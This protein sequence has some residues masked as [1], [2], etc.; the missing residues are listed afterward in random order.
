[1]KEE[2]NKEL[3]E[4]IKKIVKESPTESPSFD[5]TETVMSRIT[6]LNESKVTVYRPLI[7]KLI[8]VFVVILFLSLLIYALL[9]GNETESLGWFD[10]LNY[11]F[12]ADS[13]SG[14]EIS[15]TTLYGITFF[16]VMLCLQ[17]PLLKQHF[18]KHLAAN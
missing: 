9:F 7:S 12:I 14:L 10:T 5:F 15:K 11:G 17:I 3:N 16:T 18:D 4:F 13:F 1:M 8:W 2:V 6:K